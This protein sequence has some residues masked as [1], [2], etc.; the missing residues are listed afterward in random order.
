[1]NDRE[2]FINMIHGNL[3]EMSDIIGCLY[4]ASKRYLKHTGGSGRCMTRTA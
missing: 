1:M 3:S 4:L 2:I